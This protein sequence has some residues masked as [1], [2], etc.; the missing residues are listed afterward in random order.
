MYTFCT[1]AG[2][3]TPAVNLTRGSSLS[4]R[5]GHAEHTTEA[6]LYNITAVLSSS[7]NKSYSASFRNE[8]EVA[9]NTDVLPHYLEICPSRAHCD[10]L[11]ADC[12]DCEFNSTCRYGANVSAT[13]HVKPQIMCLV[14]T[15][16]L[17]FCITCLTRKVKVEICC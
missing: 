1:D 9:D 6:T 5:S 12:I 13:C 15:L 17:H 14:C 3:T 11:G 16:S 8:S 2:H 7:A 10:R 4:V